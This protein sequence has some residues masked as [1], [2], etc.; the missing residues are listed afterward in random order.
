MKLPPSRRDEPGEAAADELSTS[1][2]ARA[3]ALGA[4]GAELAATMLRA[5]ARRL[6]GGPAEPLWPAAHRAGAASMIRTLGRLRGAA[7]KLGQALA[8]TPGVLP[9]EYVDAL[10]ALTDDLP[11]MSYGLV[12]AQI[13]DELGAA[14][15][16]LFATFERE[17]VAAASLGQVHRA[18]LG[19]GTPVAVKVQYPAID[20]TMRSD[21]AN[22]EALV[23]LLETVTRRSDLREAVVEVRERLTEELDYRLE[24][25]HYELFRRNLAG[26]PIHI[27][28][29]YR[30]RSAERVLTLDFVEG[31]SIRAFLDGGPSQ[32]ERNRLTRSLIRFAWTTLYHHRVVHADP[33]PGNYLVCAD[34]RLG[35]VDFG[36]VKRLTP[37][38]VDR[39]RGLVR[40]A[41]YAG[42]AEL[43][44]EIV[45]AGLVGPDA[46]R[47]Q[48]ATLGR[49][50]R[51]WGRSG[52]EP[53]FDF[54]DRSY[55][56][57]LIDLQQATVRDPTLRMDPEWIFL[58][59]AFVGQTHLLYK[60]G[61]R[62][63]FRELFEESLGPP[64]A[65]A[66]AKPR[67]PRRAPATRVK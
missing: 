58:G 62:G 67:K 32:E 61:A 16:D 33:N 34:G 8:H 64:P 19:D 46:G 21:L 18:T 49:L 39:M 35:V 22:L 65:A 13:R 51:L 57:E 42:D 36:C 15:L 59:R 45:A 17:P 3:L 20:E 27:P 63:N 50:M 56:D 53:E 44:D 30:E 9:D 24:A 6:T 48:R 55:L 47:E 14:P 26:E 11:P 38:F 2:G 52:S 43:D 60:L 54:G 23:P 29:V 37:A 10:V 31:A 1:R 7:A 66:A 41:A 40:A 5:G 28:A 25:D 12:K 4:M